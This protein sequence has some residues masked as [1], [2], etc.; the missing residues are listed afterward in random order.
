LSSI[1]L[2]DALEI[3]RGRG[4]SSSHSSSSGEGEGDAATTTTTMSCSFLHASP[5]FRS[6]YE[7]VGGYVSV[8]SEWSVVPISL[9][10]LLPRGGGGGGGDQFVVVRR[11]EFPRDAARL[12]ELHEEYSE[13]R[14]VTVVRSLEYWRGYV[15]AELGDTLWVAVEG[16]GGV[17]YP[18][19]DSGGIVAWLSARERGGGR[20][21]LREFGADRERITTTSAMRVLLCAALSGRMGGGGGC[22]NSLADDVDGDDDKREVVS[23]LLPSLVLSEI[24]E[25]SRRNGDNNDEDEID[26]S[27]SLSFVNVEEGIE[28]NDDGWMYVNFDESSDNARPGVVDLITLAEDRTP[29]LIW[30]TDSF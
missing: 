14:F 15:G 30:P 25:E 16:D 12:R 21:Q 27:T 5:D 3:M 9:K 26:D 19:D 11:A 6:Y 17:D 2:R 24:R 13:K 4:S 20:I 29:H 18:S 22:E 28:E 1:L 23:L 7:K 8:R 10:R